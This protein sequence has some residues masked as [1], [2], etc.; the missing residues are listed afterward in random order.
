MEGGAGSIPAPPA[1]VR[2]GTFCNFGV[3]SKSLRGSVRVAKNSGLPTVKAYIRKLSHFALEN[4]T[5]M[6]KKKTRKAAFEHFGTKQRNLRWSCSARSSDGKMVVVTLWKDRFETRDGRSVYE[7]CGFDSD[8]SGFSL[9]ERELMRN[10]EWVQG[11][12]GGYF[13]VIV[14]IARDTSA[15][16]RRIKECFPSKLIMRLTHLNAATGAFASEAEEI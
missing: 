14:A 6:T 7:R 10:L 8:A 11:N 16:S 1:V 12:C 13:S 4:V 15:P 5:K 2:L 3:L 9:R